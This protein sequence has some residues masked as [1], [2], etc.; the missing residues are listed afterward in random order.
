MTGSLK[1]SIGA[2]AQMNTSIF[3]ADASL[4]TSHLAY[5]GHNANPMTHVTSSVVVPNDGG[6]CLNGCVSKFSGICVD[7][8]A[9]IAN[10]DAHAAC[11][12]QCL[13]G[14]GTCIL[15]CTPPPSPP[16]PPSNACCPPHLRCCCGDCDS[17]TCS[18]SC[19]TACPPPRLCPHDD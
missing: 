5:Q 14:L 8:C 12:A 18:G 9:S 10:Q 19:R 11:Y 4:Y 1:I 13:A 6:D 3:T 16:P 2:N 17:G 15:T 7:S